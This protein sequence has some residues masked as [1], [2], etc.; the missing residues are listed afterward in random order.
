MAADLLELSGIGDIH[1]AQLDYYGQRTAVASSDSCIYI[2]D[3][4]DG[5]SNRAVLKGHEGP[6]WKVAWAHPKF[7]MNRSSVVASCSYDMKVIVWK[8]TNPGQWQIAHCD[9]SHTASVNSVQFCPW[10][11]GL[12]LACASSDGTVSMLTH[13][14]QDQQWHR[15]SFQAHACGAQDIS[16]APSPP[17]GSTNPVARIATG[18]CDH[19]V[20]IWRFENEC[21]SQEQPPLPTGHSDWVRSVAWRPDDVRTLATGS[22]DKTV[23]IWEQAFVGSPN[24]LRQQDAERCWR[25]L[26]KLQVS[27]KV[28]GLAWSETGG[29]LAVSF[30][31]AETKLYK[32]TGDREYVEVAKVLEAGLQ[33]VPNSLISSIADAQVSGPKVSLETIS[34][35]DGITFPKKGDMLSMHYTGKIAATGAKF[36]SSHDRQKAFEFQIGLGKVIDGWDLGVIQMSLGQ[37]ALLKVPYALGY[38]EEGAGNG[39]IPAMADLLFEV[40]LLKIN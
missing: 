38:G 35:G 13:S 23:I 37:K 3:V 30:G 32:E 28:E 11:F 17:S 27:D 4:V 26:A 22:W 40:E 10:E 6:V 39:V 31:D 5:K 34:P 15:T 8:E 19:A 16:W 29:V 33:D 36:D 9:T 14:P 20:K 25:Q 21:W 7:G 18:G 12:R 1:D 2:F 24:S